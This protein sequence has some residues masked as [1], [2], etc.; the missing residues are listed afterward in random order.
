MSTFQGLAQITKGRKVV[1]IRKVFFENQNVAW[2]N[3]L[4]LWL[5]T[6]IV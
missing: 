4:I 1:F 5:K 2:F 6:L 3:L